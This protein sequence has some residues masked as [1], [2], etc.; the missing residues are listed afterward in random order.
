MQL[1]SGDLGGKKVVTRELEC[2]VLWSGY[3]RNCVAIAKFSGD[4]K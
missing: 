2:P 4:L 3:E 1:V